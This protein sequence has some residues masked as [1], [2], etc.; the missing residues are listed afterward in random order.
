MSNNIL[1]LKRK[2][3]KIREKSRGR[4][5]VEMLGVLAIIGVLSI[6]GISGYTIAM[7]KYRANEILSAM[8]KYAMT[9]Y[10]TC[11]NELL[12]K[13]ET[14]IDWSMA[15]GVIKPALNCSEPDQYL[16]VGLGSYPSGVTGK[17]YFILSLLSF[18]HFY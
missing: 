13:Q 16:N 11:Q 18:S 15:G 17:L 10:A 9:I 1:K 14:V 7:R 4:S 5:M 12:D 3:G 8:Q 6:G 2:F